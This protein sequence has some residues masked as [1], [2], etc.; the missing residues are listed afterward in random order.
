MN[1]IFKKLINHFLYPKQ[2]IFFDIRKIYDI[3]CYLMITH[4][5]KVHIPKTEFLIKP[6]FIDLLNLYKIILKRKPK[7]VLEIG[8]GCSTWVILSS[9]QKNY[10][11]DNIK[12]TFF[13]MEQNQEYLEKMKS[14][15]SVNDFKI[16]QFMKTDLKIQKIN[17]EKVSICDPLP[18]I[19]INFLYE[20]REDH[21]E[22]SIAADALLIEHMMPDDYFICVDG[23][24][25]T[26]MFFKKNL[27]RNY[28]IS[29]G[30]F[31]GTNFEPKN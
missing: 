15:F 10:L 6:D 4:Y 2:S 9:L 31:S 25:T 14:F 1:K 13:S 18:K 23:M 27:K 22:T 16:L 28:S 7:C 20:D 30:I 21:A 12:P 8:A 24:K 19:K 3:Y 17:G 26:V 5:Y 11:N 29:K